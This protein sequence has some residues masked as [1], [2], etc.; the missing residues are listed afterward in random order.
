MR[1]S[2]TSSTPRLPAGT[3]RRPPRSTARAI[4]T[5][6]IRQP[7]GPE[8]RSRPPLPHH[9]GEQGEGDGQFLAPLDL[10][11][12]G[13]G[14][15]YVTDWGRDGVQVFTA[16]GRFLAA[17]GADE[18]WPNPGGITV[19]PDGNLWVAHFHAHRVQQYS[20]DGVLLAT[21]GETGSGEGQF[22][23]PSDVA[24][25]EAGPRLRGRLRATTGCR[26]S[27]ATGGS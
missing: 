8:V 13:Q 27:P 10:A 1:A 21:W 2:S 15:V 5:S 4:S 12:D 16:D 17:W 9:L 19:A 11:L 18:G 24:V 6:S 25:D 20:P 3:A 7:P 26:S 23:N 22:L 14:R